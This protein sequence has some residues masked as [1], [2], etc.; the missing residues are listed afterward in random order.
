MILSYSRLRHSPHSEPS[1]TC[2]LVINFLA[3]CTHRPPLPLG[4]LQKNKEEQLNRLFK[5]LVSRAT[6]PSVITVVT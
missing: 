3:K 4:V 6:H 5:M 2:L 1:Q